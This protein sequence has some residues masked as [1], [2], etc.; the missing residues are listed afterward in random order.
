MTNWGW[1]IVIAAVTLGLKGP[2]NAKHRYAAA[3]FVVFVAILYAAVRQ[4]T[5]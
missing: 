5:Y 2:I 3:C 1:V 4:H